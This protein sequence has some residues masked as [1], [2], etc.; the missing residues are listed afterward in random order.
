MVDVLTIVGI[1][2]VVLVIVILAAYVASLYNRLVR[3]QERAENA[4]ADI[5]VLL[6][7]RSDMVEKLVDTA[8]Q[9][10]DYEQEFMTDLVEAREQVQQAD[11]PQDQ[12]EAGA[13]LSNALG[14]L[15]VRAEDHPEPQAIENMQ[16]LQDEIAQIEEQIADR[17]EVYNE[18]A[19]AQ[20]QL[21][22]TIPYVLVAGPL[23]FGRREL[24]EPPQGDREDVDI[25]QMFSDAGPEAGAAGN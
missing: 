25:D 8:Q 5:D 7:Q 17:R 9:A 18:S 22:R 13:A 16:Q 3:V 10:M 12:A 24:Y 14:N 20:N 1:L 23:G 6:K 21:I 4:W 11:S 2:A 19:T 15:N